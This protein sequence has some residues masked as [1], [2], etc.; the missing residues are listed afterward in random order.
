MQVKVNFSVVLEPSHPLRPVGRL[1]ST[2]CGPRTVYVEVSMPFERPQ[3]LKADLP[4]REVQENT[5]YI[6]IVSV[7]TE[8]L[9]LITKQGRIFSIPFRAE[10]ILKA[11]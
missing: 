10:L 6:A 11:A 5:V 4:D 2:G 8:T 7:H 3:L 1:D 9:H